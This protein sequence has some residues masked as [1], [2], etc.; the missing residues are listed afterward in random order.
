MLHRITADIRTFLATQIVE[1]EGMSGRAADRESA[2]L[3][4][5]ENTGN[6]WGVCVTVGGVQPE[7][8]EAD[9]RGGRVSVVLT[10]YIGMPPGMPADADK[11]AENLQ[12]AWMYV[13]SWMV[14]VRWGSMGAMNEEVDGK[15]LFRP[16][17]GF[18]DG[19]RA[20]VPTGTAEFTRVRLAVV[21]PDQKKEESKEI[22]LATQAWT[23]S[24]SLPIYGDAEDTGDFFFL[25]GTVTEP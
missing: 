9:R 20:M 1:V 5:M 13:W 7:G 4:L 17:D 19:G 22:L 24:A 25:P 12:L 11:R 21:T 8:T 18:L 6:R 2:L 10:L 14:R 23:L 3:W 15:A 16:R